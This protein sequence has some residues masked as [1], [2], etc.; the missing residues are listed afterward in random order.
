DALRG[1]VFTTAEALEH[2]ITPSMLRGRRIATVTPGVFRYAETAM[3]L[4]LAI[5]AALAVLPDDAAVSHTTNLAWRGLT[6]R[7]STPLHFA[8]MQD[9]RS[10]RAGILLHRYQR[11]PE[12][13]QVDG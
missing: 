9:I 2:G 11:R 13:E 8:T 3:T 10:R 12:V 1:R 7:P 5:R 4:S 6:L